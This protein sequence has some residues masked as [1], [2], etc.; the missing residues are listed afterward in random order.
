MELPSVLLV[1]LLVLS[2]QNAESLKYN[3]IA[4]YYSAYRKRCEEK[5]LEARETSADAV[6][7]GTI[8]DLI[9]DRHDQ[10]QKVEFVYFSAR[11]YI[12]SSREL[13]AKKT[14]V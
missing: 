14:T 4:K 13:I 9:P 11:F 12:F 6:F 1:S 5:S 7:T 3:S 10:R 2:F 8:R